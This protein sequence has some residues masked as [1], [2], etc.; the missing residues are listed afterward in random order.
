MTNF[1]LHEYKYKQFFCEENIW[2]LT[3]NLNTKLKSDTVVLFLTNNFDFI[4]LKHQKLKTFGDYVLF[5]YHVILHDPE[6]QLIYD[7]DSDLGF[8]VDELEYFEKTFE[9]QNAID[10][11]YRTRVIP[12]PGKNYVN[13]FSSDRSHMYDDKGRPLQPFPEWP[14]ISG[15]GSL[16]LKSL[17]AM[18][19]SVTSRWS[20]LNV[21]DYLKANS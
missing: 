6:K 15:D 14:P 20:D 19:K 4:A 1:S 10:K 2:H 13:S 5:D 16:N 12:I 9:N 21:F 18:D 8:Q 17:I 7:F 11:S 3:V